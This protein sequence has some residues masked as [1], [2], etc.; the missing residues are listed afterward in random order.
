MA[1]IDAPTVLAISAHAADFVWRCGG[2]LIRYREIGGRVVVVTLTFGERGESDAL[3]Q[4]T[5]GIGVDEVKAIR[6]TEAERAAAELDVEI[7]FLDLNDFPLVLDSERDLRLTEQVREIRPGIVLT[8]A[9]S[10]P[11]NP[12]HPTASA[13]VTRQLRLATVPGL[14]PDLS[15][16]APFDVLH[17]EPDLPEMCGFEPDTYLDISDVMPRKLA[18][19]RCMTTQEYLVDNYTRRAEYRGYQARRFAGGGDIRYAEAYR[20]LTPAVGRLFH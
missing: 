7:R 20:R 13:A 19:M 14:L 2:A 15:P 6:R 5:P 11:M 17:F 18:A 16:V 1:G 8:H 4:S 9:A 3:W 10:D 12:D